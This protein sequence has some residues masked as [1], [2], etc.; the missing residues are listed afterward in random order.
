LDKVDP[1]RITEFEKKFVEHVK[2]KQQPLLD[3]ISKDGQLSEA[4]DAALK[5]VVLDFMA[6]F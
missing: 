2:A 3:Q 6:T 5:K 1:A 4:S